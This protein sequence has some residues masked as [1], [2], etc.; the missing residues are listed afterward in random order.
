MASYV[1]VED[2]SNELNGLT[3]DSTTTP[4]ESTVDTWIEQ[5]SEMLD[6]E[7]GRYW[8]V[9]ESSNEY[10]DYDGSGYIRLNKAPVVDISKIEYESSENVWT[11]LTSGKYNDYIIYKDEGELRLYNNSVKAGYQNI[12]VTYTYGYT[13]TPRTV[14]AIVSKRVALRVIGAVIN[15]QSSEEGGSITVGAISIS[16]P[17]SV[18]LQRVQSL[19]NDIQ[20]MI[21]SLGKF[22]TF[23]YNRRW[24]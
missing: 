5:E 3:I 20:S 16:D 13:T 8:G 7:T 19:K 4:S 14:V 22:K 1:T 24:V 9:N 15:S 23:R 10:L 2:V 11:E 21:G 17:S 12:R 6:K 18:S